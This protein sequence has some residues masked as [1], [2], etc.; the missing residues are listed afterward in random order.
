MKKDK[1]ARCPPSLKTS[2]YNYLC[3]R[4]EASKPLRSKKLKIPTLRK[5]TYLLFD[6]QME[7]RPRYQDLRENFLLLYRHGR[8]TKSQWI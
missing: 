8:R 4:K 7:K 3:A 5:P 2:Y 1:I 6:V